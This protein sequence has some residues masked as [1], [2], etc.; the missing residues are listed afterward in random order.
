VDWEDVTNKNVVSGEI[1]DGTIMNDDVSGNAAIAFSKL[2]MSAADVLGLSPY[3]GG[4]GVSVDSDTGQISIGQSVETGDSPE[5]SGMILTGGLSAT[6][7]TIT[8]N[9][10]V[11]DGSLLTGVSASSA[12]SVD[13][14]DVTNKNVVSGE[15][16]DGTIMN[17]DVSGNAA[18]A[19][20][21]LSMSSANVRGLSPYSAGTGVSVGNDGVISIGQSVETGDSPTFN[22][23]TLTGGLNVSQTVTANKFVGDGS[24]LTNLPEAI[25]EGYIENDI[26]DEYIPYNNGTK[27][28]ASGL[29]W[30]SSNA[31]M[32]IG[33]DSPTE[34]LDVNGTI[35]ATNF[36]KSDG[37]AIGGGKWDD[38]SGGINY[39]NG[40]VGIN[41]NTSDL[42]ASLEVYGG[43]DSFGTARFVSTKSGATG[44]HS[45]IHYGTTAD[46]FI[47]SGSTAGKVVIQDNGGNVG[48]GTQAPEQTLHVIKKGTGNNGV[49]TLFA[50]DEGS[51]SWGVVSEFRVNSGS[52]R[53][54][55]LF[56]HGANNNQTWS[57]GFYKQTGN[58]AI[59]QNHGYRNNSWG[60]NRFLIDTSGRVGI[61]TTNP[62]HALDV[63]GSIRTNDKLRI[64]GSQGLEF[65]TYGGGWYMQD[66][67]WIRA[68]GGKSIYT[69]SGEIRSDYK[70]SA[71]IFVDQND[72]SYYV[73]PASTSYVNDLR[74][75]IIY[76]RNNTSYYLDPASTSY[77][78]DL[79]ANI[80]YDRNDTSYYLN[81]NEG[82]KI[83]QLAFNRDNYSDVMMTMKNTSDLNYYIWGEDQNGQNKFYINK[84]GASKIKQLAFNRDN[85][86]NVMMTMKNSSNLPFFIWGE[87]QYGQNKF[88]IYSDGA[89]SQASDIRY[90]KNV[91][92][93]ENALEKITRVRGVMYHWNED[94]DTATKSIGVIAQ[95]IEAEF[96]NLVHTHNGKKSVTYDG[97]API[98]IEAI[99]TLKVEKDTEM[100]GLKD[101]ND[102]LKKDNENLKIQLNELIKRV[103]ALEAQ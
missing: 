14:E 38:F 103:E 17:D 64:S 33:T 71:P 100:Q 83:K 24:G 15:I 20:S 93:I 68:S 9:S 48:I 88:Y 22:G 46:W 89:Y 34:T 75:N 57:V 72:G 70:M 3:S 92:T 8:A 32:G 76:D 77:V 25:L 36:V 95:E 99:K 39:S 28:V 54:S 13:W 69:S 98:L 18:I 90:K 23:M 44:E 2:S 74:A 50:N 10:F 80:I 11:G 96:P 62:S 31:R 60:T 101:A 91:M 61:G 27:L 67:T 73:D 40:N 63:N 29:K 7:Q 58:F 85:F 66:S 16:A 82:S 56:S 52:D 45:Y 47:R 79:R 19:F 81:P 41:S 49:A 30:D 6:G 42:N 65:E 84:N 87:D 26:T 21:K 35:K 86:S 5:F 97:I 12:E 1:A 53:P 94:P 59:N 55:I 102:A 51:H 37:T 78:N 4:T 43:T